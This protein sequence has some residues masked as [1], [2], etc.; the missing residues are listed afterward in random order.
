MK[1]ANIAG[2]AGQD[3]SYLAELLVEKG[4]KVLGFLKKDE[5]TSYP[6]KV[7]KDVVLE[8]R[9]KKFLGWVSEV[10]FPRLVQMMVDSQL[11]RFKS[12]R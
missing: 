5:D 1:R 11:E 2:V 9:A 6:N 7:I 3:G 8:S 10:R 12:Q 4:Y